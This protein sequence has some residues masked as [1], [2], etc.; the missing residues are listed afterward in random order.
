MP[1]EFQ[2]VGTN[3]VTSTNGFTVEVNFGGGV[4]YFDAEGEVRMDSE[5]LANPHAILLYKRG[6]EEVANTARIQRIF[7]NVTRA[8]E[9]MGHPVQIWPDGKSVAIT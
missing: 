8:L 3:K 2:K 4:R 6:F 5:W 7:S 9:Y 1:H